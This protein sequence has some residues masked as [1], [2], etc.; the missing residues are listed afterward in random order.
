MEDI[1]LYFKEELLQRPK[2]GLEREGWYWKEIS[3]DHGQI[4]SRKYYVENDVEWF[5]IN[6]PGWKR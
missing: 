2:K 4:E 1:L 6:Y 5:K 3:F